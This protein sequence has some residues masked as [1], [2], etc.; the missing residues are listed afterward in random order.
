PLRQSNGYV[1]G[2]GN[3]AIRAVVADAVPSTGG[4]PG[5]R[6]DIAHR[7]EAQLPFEETG[8]I[9]RR[10]WRA[11]CPRVR[12]DV[13]VIA[14]RGKELRPR[15]APYHFVEAKRGV[16]EHLRLTD[17]ADMEVHVADRRSRRHA[18]PRLATRGTD[19]RAQIE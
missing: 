9:G 3:Y 13:V 1:P 6:A 5:R 10:D 2:I 8:V 16:I 4:V 14:A 12:A 11:G 19:E 7:G 17:R 15:I 18:A